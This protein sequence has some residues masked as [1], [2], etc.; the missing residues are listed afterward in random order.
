M[1]YSLDIPHGAFHTITA[2]DHCAWPNL[3]LLPNGDIGAVIFNQ[4]S[5]GAMEGD[6]ELW[7]SDDGADTWALRSQITRHDP[8]T[9]RMNVAA[10]LNHKGD[11]VVLCSGWDLE[12]LP[13]VER[14]EAI[15][16]PQVWISADNGHTWELAGEA[17]AP[18]QCINSIPFGNVVINADELLVGCYAAQS[19][20]RG[21]KLRKAHVMRSADGGRTW[22]D[23]TRIA[24]TSSGEPTL[25]LTKDGSL[26]AAIRDLYPSAPP[27]GAELPPGATGGPLVLHRSQDMGRTWQPQQYLSLAHQIPGSLLQ[28][29]DGRIVA[30][31][32]SRI[33][34][35][36]GV[37]AR[38][39]ED[40]GRNWSQPFALVAGFLPQSDHGYPSSVQLDGG[41]IVTAYYCS[42]APWYQRYHMG[43]LRWNLDMVRI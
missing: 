29:A 32:G 33:N 42:A 38:V 2:P 26:L 37:V 41:D 7:V 23:H 17:P 43:V 34:E 21:Y 12:R 3:T 8:G 40:D 19:D 35:C 30:T 31:Y 11:L 39:S 22:G 16:L 36:R 14:S 27:G 6:V 5:H 13:H 1:A 25:L 10:G 18:P 4:P 20:Q 15:L 9:N 28:L 24:D